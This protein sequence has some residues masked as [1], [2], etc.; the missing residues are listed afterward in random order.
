M[1]EMRACKECG[2]MFM[3]KGREKYCSDVHYRPCPVCGTLVVVKY[4]SD[5]PA[6]CDNCKGKHTKVHPASKAKAL[7]DINEPNLSKPVILNINLAQA[8]KFEQKVKEVANKELEENTQ[9]Q[10]NPSTV[11]EVSENNNL[12]SIQSGQDPEKFC[13]E[14]DGKVVRYIGP[15]AAGQHRFIN[16]HDYKIA[17]NRKDNTYLLTSSH[18]LTTGE[19]VSCFYIFSSQISVGTRFGIVIQ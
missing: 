9:T 17:M 14:L 3:P 16:N 15:T 4:L 10:V 6:K 19:E 11:A 8:A 18:D 1:S 13:E 12:K 7:F 5:P 2:K